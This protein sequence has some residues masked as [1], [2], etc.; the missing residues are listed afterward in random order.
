M[1]MPRPTE[2]HRRLTAFAGSWTGDERLHP[3]PWDAKGG[4]ATTK[5]DARMG[6]DGFALIQDA[7]Q[8]REGRYTLLIETSL[9]GQ[10]W[11]PFLE[12]TYTR[13]EM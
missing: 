7:Q 11:H 10:Q 12:G 4:P 13:R 8:E 2:E 5:V 1:D 9:D 6:L 3:S